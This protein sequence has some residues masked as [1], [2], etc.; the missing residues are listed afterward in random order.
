MYQ[1]VKNLADENEIPFE[2][3]SE[4]HSLA[5]MAKTYGIQ[6]DPAGPGLYL[7]VFGKNLK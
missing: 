3:Q 6:P 5:T 7:T 1:I 4:I 2:L